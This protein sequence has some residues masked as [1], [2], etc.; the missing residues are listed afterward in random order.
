MG[1]KQK[2]TYNTHCRDWL[3]KISVGTV[4]DSLL[5]VKM[6]NQSNE[7]HAGDSDGLGC[8]DSTGRN[9]CCQLLGCS[10]FLDALDMSLCLAG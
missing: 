9:C 8:I 2:E 7:G 3:S 5:H 4:S 10:S 6:E 1:G